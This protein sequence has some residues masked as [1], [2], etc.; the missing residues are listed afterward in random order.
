M[1]FSTQL[2]WKF[3]VVSLV[4]FLAC[5]VRHEQ[6][7]RHRQRWPAVCYICCFRLTSSNAK[8][9][10]DW[11]F[12]TAF[13]PVS[14]YSVTKFFV[15]CEYK[16]S[17]WCFAVPMKALLS[18]TLHLMFMFELGNEQKFIEYLLQWYLQQRDHPSISTLKGHHIA[19]F[20]AFWT[21]KSLIT[22]LSGSDSE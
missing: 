7:I 17:T 19:V 4:I 22:W 12:K 5:H 2:L 13:L 16:D 8:N 1:A 18:S 9:S 20:V 14:I 15:N 3:D 11:G 10:W 6:C 21:K